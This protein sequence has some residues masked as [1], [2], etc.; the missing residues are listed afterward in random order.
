M[1]VPLHVII[2]TLYAI[3]I[4]LQLNILLPAYNVQI[5]KAW[6]PVS[7]HSANIVQRKEAY[8]QNI[9]ASKISRYTVIST[10]REEIN[11]SNE[12]FLCEIN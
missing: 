4:L 11:S 8:P 6:L 9:N 12:I 2:I 3:K 1:Y 10:Y 7:S 5:F